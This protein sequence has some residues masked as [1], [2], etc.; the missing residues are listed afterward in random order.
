MQSDAE[1]VLP[2]SAVF[3]SRNVKGKASGLAKVN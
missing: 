2:G 1:A 3:A